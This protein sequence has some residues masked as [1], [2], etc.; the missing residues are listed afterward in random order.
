MVKLSGVPAISIVKTGV[1]S[2][3]YITYNFVIKN[4]GNSVLT[5][6]TLTD[7]MLGLT[8]VTITLPAGGLQPGV[9]TFYSAKYTLT[10]ANITAGSVTNVASATG[11][12]ATGA[13]ASQSTS[14]TNNLPPAPVAPPDN[15]VVGTNSYTI[16][17]LIDPNAADP[18]VP[19]TIEIVTPPKHGTVKIN[20]DGTVT[21][22]PNPGY[23]GPDSFTY[24]GKDARGFY[25]N[26]AEVGI[27]V[28]FIPAFKIPTLFTPNGDGINDT[29]VIEGLSANYPNNEIIIVNRWGN[30]VYHSSNYDGTWAGTGLNEG[31][32]YYLLHIKNVDGSDIQVIKGYITLLRSTK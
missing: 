3:T 13:S 22:I 7:V 28:G 12:D 1:V 17:K 31:T 25:T 32:Y 16:I 5:S 21:Y 24:R 20:A 2:D 4:T 9:G 27:S 6:V 10:Q 29:F 23:T 30:E 18:I 11:T 26:N 14:V 15:T 8:G 19:G